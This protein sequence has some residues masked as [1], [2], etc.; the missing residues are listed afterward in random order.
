M[1]LRFEVEIAESTLPRASQATTTTSM[2]AMLAE[3][4]LVPW[5][6]AGIRHTLRCG[7]PRAA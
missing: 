1:P 4:G 3:A 6:E 7:S 5:A 2:P